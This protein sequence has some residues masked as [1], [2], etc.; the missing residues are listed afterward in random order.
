MAIFRKEFVHIRRDRATLIIALMIPLFQ[1]MLF[2][3]IDQTVHEPPDGRRRPGRT[4]RRRELM[5]KLRATH[6]FRSST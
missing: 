1:L 5:D 2:G 6:T 4:A 3:F